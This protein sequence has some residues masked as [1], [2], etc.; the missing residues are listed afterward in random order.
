LDLIYGD[1]GT[2]CGVGIWLI[3]T[4]LWH[5]IHM[6]SFLRG[7]TARIA[8]D[9][10]VTEETAAKLSNFLD[11]LSDLAWCVPSEPD[12]DV[13]TDGG[14]APSTDRTAYIILPNS[15]K[16]TFNLAAMDILQQ[17][18][19][20]SAPLNYERRLYLLTQRSRLHVCETETLPYNDAQAYADHINSMIDAQ[21]NSA[22]A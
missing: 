2:Y 3:D 22:I 13:T 10:R 16:P 21:A 17:L 11:R 9:N 19:T 5:S 15:Q 6:I 1:R 4:L 20:N 12:P 18:F 14:Y 7:A 8:F